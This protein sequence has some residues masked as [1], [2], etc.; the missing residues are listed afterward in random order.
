MILRKSVLERKS[1]L[2]ETAELGIENTRVGAAFSIVSLDIGP[3]ERHF[4]VSLSLSLSIS[5]STCIPAHTLQE[6]PMKITTYGP[7]PHKPA[8]EGKKLK[9]KS[10]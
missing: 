2:C 8:W 10:E 3:S 9:I 6:I 7:Y 5:I 1:R 4:R